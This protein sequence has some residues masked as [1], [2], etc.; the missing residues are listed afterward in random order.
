LD[1]AMVE[2]NTPATGGSQNADNRHRE[3]LGH[4]R[5]GPTGRR[6]SDQVQHC[7]VQTVYV[8]REDGGGKDPRL[9]AV[10]VTTGI[11]DNIHT[12]VL[13]GLSEGDRVV[14]GLAIPGLTREEAIHNPFS[15]RHQ[16]IKVTA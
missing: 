14:T 6:N 10:E 1:L 11:T 2:T 5:D 4:A 15:F 13:S 12:E 7:T 9:E 3:K 16:A 8:L